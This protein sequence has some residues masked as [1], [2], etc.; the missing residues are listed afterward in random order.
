MNKHQHI[1]SELASWM[2][3]TNLFESFKAFCAAK[4]L[5]SH[6]NSNVLF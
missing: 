6:K 3:K 5:S 4:K 1:E 2:K